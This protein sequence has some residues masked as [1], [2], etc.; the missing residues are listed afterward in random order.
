MFDREYGL[1]RISSIFISSRSG[2]GVLQFVKADLIITSPE[3]C[4]GFATIPGRLELDVAGKRG[5]RFLAFQSV[6][7]DGPSYSLRS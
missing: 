7:P 1:E 5:S 4:V 3:C 6:P 2:D